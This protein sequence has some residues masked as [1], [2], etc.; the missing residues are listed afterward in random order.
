MIRKPKNR[1]KKLCTGN[2]TRSRIN[3]KEKYDKNYGNNRKKVALV[4][5]A[6]FKKF[7]NRNRVAERNRTFAQRLGNKKPA[8]VSSNAQTKR[9]PKSFFYAAKI[10]KARKPHQKPGRRVRS[11]SRKRSYPRTNISSTKKKVRRSVVLACI[12]QTNINHHAQIKNKRADFCYQRP[13]HKL[14]P[15]NPVF[16]GFLSFNHFVSI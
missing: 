8:N 16:S 15:K 11:F 9:S 12:A 10:A 14:L 1:I 4:V 13:I 6:V 5:Q 3:R 7:R 2:K